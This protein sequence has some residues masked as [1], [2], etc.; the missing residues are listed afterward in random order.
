[1]NTSM[2]IV[3]GIE[4]LPLLFEWSFESTHCSYFYDEEENDARIDD[5]YSF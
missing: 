1:M 4:G 5:E 3:S 2:N